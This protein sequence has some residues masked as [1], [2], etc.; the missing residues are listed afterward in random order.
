MEEVLTVFF[1]K[2]SERD[3]VRKMVDKGYNRKY[4]MSLL[5][6]M[7]KGIMRYIT[8]DEHFASIFSYHF[9]ILNHFRHDRRISLPFYL[10]SSLENSLTNHAKNDDNPILHEGL[11]MLIMEHNKSHGV[12]P[13]PVK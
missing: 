11:I 7:A 5:A 3:R 12:K 1:N 6:D 13:S 4:L 9:M 2:Q 8:L 10:L